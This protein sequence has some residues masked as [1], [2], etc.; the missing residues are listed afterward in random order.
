ML[1]SKV[2]VP[3]ELYE[4]NILKASDEDLKKISEELGLALSVET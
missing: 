1:Y 4:I 2:D 3:F